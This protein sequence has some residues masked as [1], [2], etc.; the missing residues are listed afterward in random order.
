MNL[1]DSRNFFYIRLYASIIMGSGIVLA[2]TVSKW[3]SL[4]CDRTLDRCQVHSGN[5]LRSTQRT[6]PIRSLQGATIDTKDI[7][8]RNGYITAYTYR[9]LLL[10]DRTPLLENYWGG[11]EPSRIASAIENFVK[12]PQLRSLQVSQDER[13]QGILGGIGLNVVGILLLQR[14][15]EY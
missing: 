14:C 11:N 4:N 8:N 2:L 15:R 13:W 7:R 6:F 12:N 5:L 10:P 1:F 9:V 3:G